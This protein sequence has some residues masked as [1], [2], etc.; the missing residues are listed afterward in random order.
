PD[1]DLWDLSLDNRRMLCF[2]K[3]L[4]SIRIL[5]HGVDSLYMFDLGDS[6]TVPWKL[7]VPLASTAL[8]IC[9]LPE[10]MSEKELAWDLVQNGI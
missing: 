9:C 10:G 5:K 4:S 7:A 6:S 1:P 2:T 3:C 8:Y